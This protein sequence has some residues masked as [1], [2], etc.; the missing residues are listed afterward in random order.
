[1]KKFTL[2]VLSGLITAY[3]HGQG[4]FQF[5][6]HGGGFNFSLGRQTIEFEKWYGNDGLQLN[7]PQPEWKYSA[8][9]RDSIK[10]GAPKN[11][12]LLVGFQ[13]YGVVSDIIIGGELNVGI[14]SK[15]TEKNSFRPLAS[16]SDVKEYNTY[17][18]PYTADLLLNLGL[19]AYRSKGFIA[20]PMFGIGYGAT[21]LRLQDERDQRT[22]PE[23]TKPL[24]QDE[25]VQNVIVWQRNLVADAGLGLQYF[26]GSSSSD[27]AK[28]FS[29]GL[30][31]GYRI[32]PSATDL[33]LNSKSVKK[34]TIGDPNLPTNGLYV[35]L[36]IGFG[37]VGER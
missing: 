14:G 29:L 19:V 27:K 37:K 23:F 12:L 6:N 10:W 30:R 2:I 33:Q 36:L 32:Q 13:G 31:V 28:G 24:T 16:P 26:V 8:E 1:M 22:Y 9:R 20:Y 21:A 25:N 5:N 17:V 35:K 11:N 34:N 3:V 7:K 15:T 18:R 4:A